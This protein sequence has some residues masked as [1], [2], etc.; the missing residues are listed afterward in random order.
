VREALQ[1]VGLPFDEIKDR[2]PFELSGGQRRR[3]A[4][5]GVLAMKPCILILD[6]PTAGLDPRGR[7]EIFSEIQDPPPEKGNLP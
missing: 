3:V 7:D 4:I 2:S 6:E 1:L 5:A